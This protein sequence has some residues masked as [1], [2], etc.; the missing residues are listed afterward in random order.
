V[1][2]D[3]EKRL[4][5]IEKA[6]E[7]IKADLAKKDVAGA[8]TLCKTTSKDVALLASEPHPRPR[9]AVDGTRRACECDV[10]SA[11]LAAALDAID[12]APGTKKTACKDSVRYVDELKAN[13]Y[14]DDPAVQS[15]LARF[16]AV[17]AT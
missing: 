6:L 2:K 12:K 1:D 3:N 10:P 9:A 8:R 16:G 13:K 5:P 11:A 14:G 7:S 15:L 4:E 17:C